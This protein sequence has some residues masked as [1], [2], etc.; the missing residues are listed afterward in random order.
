L[1]LDCHDLGDWLGCYARPYLQTP[2]LDALAASGAA[3]DRYFATA[4][5]CMPSRAAIFTGVMP[6]MAGVT[7]QD[8]LDGRHRCLPDYFRRAGYETVCAGGLMVTNPPAEVGFERV[9]PARTDGERAVAAAGYIERRVGT[10][11]R[12]FYLHAS[13]THVHRPFGQAY[14]PAVAE[15]IPVPSGLPSTAATRRDLATLA[16]NVAEL[17]ALVGHML[18][19]VVRAGLERQTLVVFTTEHGVALARHKHTLYDGGIKTALLMRWPGAI[20]PG[21]R[22]DQLLS[23]VDLMPTVLELAGLTGPAKAPV[24]V[25]GKSFAGVFGAATLA[26][27]D[28]VF[29]EHTWGRRSGRYYYTPM[30]CVRTARWKYIRNLTDQPPYVDNGFLCRFADDRE[31]IERRFGTPSP[32]EELYD[33]DH[34]PGERRNLAGDP[35]QASTLA[36]MRTALAAFLEQTRDPVLRGV[37]PSGAGAP[38]AT[39]APQW[40]RSLDGRFRLSPDDP[41]VERELP[42]PARWQPAPA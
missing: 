8:P 34:D 27:R 41:A 35:A 20:P 5:I 40:V 32:S 29:A 19:A 11:G 36:S 22:Y 28:A 15:T 18:G 13:F 9:L 33:L 10:G 30:R 12:P 1:Y 21:R 24:A 14:D 37:V 4:P 31:A 6:H 7:G 25:L 3:F 38:D 39:D 2:H 26:G 23:N 17:D 16:R 42:F